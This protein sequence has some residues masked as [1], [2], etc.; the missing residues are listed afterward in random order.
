MRPGVRDG[1]RDMTTRKSHAWVAA[2]ALGLVVY[3]PLPASADRARPAPVD[4]ITLEGSINPASAQYTIRSISQAERDG[5]QAVIIRLD[6]PGGLADS[7]RKI[8]QKELSSRVPVIV[9]VAPDGARAASAGTYIVLAANIAAMAPV[10]NIGSAH[11]VSGFGQTM[12][13]VMSAK[14]ENDAAEYIK[15]IA[16]HRGRNV[17]WAEAA[18]RKSINSR[19]SEALEKGIID[20]IAS[21][22]RDLLEK[23]DGRKVVV[24]GES[25]S[26]Q[27]AKAHTRHIDMSFREAFLQVL[28]DPNLA[29]ILILIATYGIIFE[30]SNP[31]SILPGVLG[32]VA[33][34]LLLYSMSVL[35]VNAAG[36]ALIVLSIILFIIDLNV[37]THGILTA[38]GILS[39]L[40]GA[41][42]LFDPSSPVFRVSIGLILGGTLITAAF[43]VFLVGAGV[44]A[45]KNVVVSGSEGLVGKLGEAKTDLTP[46]GTVYADGAYWTAVTE[47]EEVKAGDKVR[48]VGV[49]GLKIRVVRGER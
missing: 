5:A 34:I 4:M 46:I 47:D 49:D 11:P 1:V 13:K 30:L 14:V 7:M 44:R 23:I 40:L 31:G 25:M 9:Y 16:S 19:A 2:L 45:Q 39:F 43:F 35:P 37:P 41:F 20:L 28:S 27:T 42:M 21:D 6:T 48:I 18:V 3:H 17:E 15:S 26:L 33:L 29:F 38:G 12:D 10:T 8:V 32:G 22:V 36:V 24:D